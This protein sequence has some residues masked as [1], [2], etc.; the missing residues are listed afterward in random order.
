VLR[1]ILLALLPVL[2]LL[3]ASEQARDLAAAVKGLELDPDASYRVNDLRFSREDLSI[4]LNHGILIFAK[5]V[6]GARPGA[7]FDA[8][9]DTGDA[10]ILVLPPNRAERLSLARF[11]GAPNLDTHFRTAVLL[12]SD[13]T[14]DELLREMRRNLLDEEPRKEPEIGAEIAARMAPS[15]RRIY[16]DYSVR[17]VHDLLSPPPPNR[18]FLLVATGGAQIGPFN[19]FYEPEPDAHITV[20]QA[21]ERDGHG[22]F[23]V[24]TSFPAQSARKATNP[25]TTPFS[26]SKFTIDATIGRDLEMTV[27]SRLAF[28]STQAA[29]RVVPLFISPRMKVTSAELDGEPAEVL[30]DEANVPETSFGSRSS[31]FLVI[32]SHPLS[33]GRHELAVHHA[34][35][36]IAETAEHIFFVGAR[37]VWYPQFGDGQADFDIT[38]R[39]P[40]QLG[41]VTTGDIV[42][43]RVEGDLR[44]TRAVTSAP[45][46][47]AG[48][49]LGDYAR[50]KITRGPYTIELC[51]NRHSMG[52][53][54]P[55]PSL[56]MPRVGPRS[57][58]SPIPLSAEI[59]AGG[60]AKDRLESLAFQTA[61]TFSFMAAILG[62][63]HIR[64]MTVSPIPG[65]FGQGFPGLIYLS[66]LAYLDPA[67]RPPEIRTRYNE[68]FFSDLLEAHEIAHQWWGNLVVPASPQDDWMM[69]SLANYTA[70]LYLEKRK[71]RV[72]V[73]TVLA[74]YKEHLLQQDA[75]G[76][77]V[78]STGPIIWGTRLQT[79][80]APEGWRVITYEKGSWI[81]HMLRQQL[82]DE[83]FHAMLRAAC[84]RFK[85]SP[86]STEQFRSLASEFMPAGAPDASLESFFENWVYGT[87]IPKL[88][89]TYS[90]RGGK[91]TGTLSQSGVDDD[92]TAWFPISIQDG[93]R[94]HTQWVQTGGDPSSFSETVRQTGA[95]AELP[96]GWLYTTAPEP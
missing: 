6:H 15:L 59:P 8:S 93:N 7:V 73:D 52:T 34:G 31:E 88:K 14:A 43:N 17:I 33:P 41:V 89:L 30:Q 60:E 48:F 83:R 2:P 26:V 4:Y 85:S 53:P 10:E 84:E 51:A 35:R 71:G 62:P 19:A 50:V 11:T 44:V 23:N 77:S 1:A 96:A 91:L 68:T 12:F 18:G 20:G 67:Q 65:T 45:V 95:L 69:E 9:S 61:A 21:V 63:P 24:W 5:P 22:F 79:S 25:S 66:T 92:F 86:L 80:D 75:R 13:G 39:Y 42:E 57:L 90:T 47:F 37:G 56:V 94:T 78:E 76:R 70:L 49:N 54:A 16:A 40:K 64:T 87:G 74:D 38:Y 32:P 29:G 72:A 46:R 82:G 27:T 3:A 36:V 81:I 55:P 28:D 58:Q